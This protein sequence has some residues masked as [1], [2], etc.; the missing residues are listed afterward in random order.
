MNV[1]AVVG[2]GD[3]G[4]GPR[5]VPETLCGVRAKRDRAGELGGAIPERA[6]CDPGRPGASREEAC[7]A[8]GAQAL[9][10]GEAD[11]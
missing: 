1:V 11:V 10:A 9:E 7:Q 2:G 3:D 4:G 5:K 6:R 8:G